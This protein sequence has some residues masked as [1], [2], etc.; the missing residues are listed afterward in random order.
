MCVCEGVGVCGC[1]GEQSHSDKY[2]KPVFWHKTRENINDLVRHRLREVDN[3][4]FY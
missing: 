3:Y 4:G 2:L 1:A